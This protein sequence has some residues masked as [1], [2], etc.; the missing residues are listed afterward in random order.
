MGFDHVS[1]N[2]GKVVYQYINVSD[3][4]KRAVKIY[5]HLVSRLRTVLIILNS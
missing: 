2:D 5:S 4:L 3:P 1:V